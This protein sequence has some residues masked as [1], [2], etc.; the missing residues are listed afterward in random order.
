[1]HACMRGS[2]EVAAADAHPLVCV[3]VCVCMCV[4]PWLLPRPAPP[5]GAL[6]W[7]SGSAR[8]RTPGMAA[9]GGPSR[10]AG[11]T[12]AQTAGARCAARPPWCRVRCVLA[13]QPWTL[14]HPF[15]VLSGTTRHPCTHATP[16][17][18]HTHAFSQERPRG[19][20]LWQ[21]L[22]DDP[23]AGLCAAAHARHGGGH[24]RGPQG[25]A[26]RAG[27]ALDARGARGSKGG[28]GARGGAARA[29]RVGASPCAAGGGDVCVCVLCVCVLCVCCVCVCVCVLPSCFGVH[30]ST[31][32]A[33]PQLTAC[34]ST[35]TLCH[36]T[37]RH[38]TPHFSHAAAPRT[39]TRTSCMTA[40]TRRAT[41]TQRTGTQ[42]RTCT[43]VAALC[44]CVC[45][46]WARA[47]HVQQWSEGVA[48]LGVL[49]V[50]H[51]QVRH[52]GS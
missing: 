23:P 18:Q 26:A 35:H 34:R 46:A 31:S 37:S 30:R 45:V 49:G 50:H 13:L 29:A 39:T 52:V 3:C 8:S 42:Q 21:P 38:V 1:M 14:R 40:M 12:T 24:D 51:L 9:P 47:R 5:S 11:R 33:S 2:V 15:G 32:L 41:R 25:R 36:V 27:G 19:L 43:C 44:V 16:H 7:A 4:C 22:G 17:L 10:S 20:V 6:R 48:L 28:G